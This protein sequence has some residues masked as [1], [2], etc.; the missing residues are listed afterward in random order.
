MKGEVKDIGTTAQ[1][2]AMA[3]GSN[4]PAFDLIT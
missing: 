2:A 1:N 4:Y 3:A